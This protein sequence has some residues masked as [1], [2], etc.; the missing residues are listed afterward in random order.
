M[1]T[2][3]L[4]LARAVT[5]RPQARE[6]DRHRKAQKTPEFKKAYRRRIAVEH[7]IGR[8][9]AM[10]MGKA[11]SFGLAKV[12]MQAAMAAMVANLGLAAVCRGLERVVAWILPTTAQGFE[13]RRLLKPPRPSCE[14]FLLGL[15]L[16][17]PLVRITHQDSRQSAGPGAF[18]PLQVTRV[19]TWTPS[20]DL[21]RCTP[22]AGCRHGVGLEISERQV[23][24]EHRHGMGMDARGLGGGRDEPQ[25]SRVLRAA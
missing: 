19:R 16:A 14:P 3:S 21:V 12:A 10:R 11:R 7:A 9:R 13:P 22:R 15:F 25:R 24:S 5:D 1:C 2:K 20:P 17:G 6:L 23:L 18:G 4:P 8:M